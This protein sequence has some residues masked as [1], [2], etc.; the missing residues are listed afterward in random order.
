MNI[1]LR[2][3]QLEAVSMLEEEVRLAADDAARRP[4]AIA[5]SAVT[6]AG[7]T[8]MVAALIERLLLGF[9]DRP[10]MEDVTM[11]WLSHQPHI[12]EQSRRRILG[13]STALG[14]DNAIV[15]ES[16][17]DRET[18][19]PGVLYFLNTQKLAVDR[20][21]TRRSDGRKYTI[22]ETIANTVEQ[23]SGNFVL[24]VDEAHYGTANGRGRKNGGQT[25][26]EHFLF[27]HPEH[28]LTQVK[29]VVGI[30]ATPQRFS[31][32]LQKR[33]DHATRPV[34]VTPQSVRESGLIKE[35]VEIVYS[36]DKSR[37]ADF[38]LLEEAARAW[39]RYTRAWEDYC[40]D[41]G[42][43]TRVLPRLVV[44]VEDARA[45]SGDTRTDL[46]LCVERIK[47]AVKG[48][49]VLD[50]TAFVHTFDREG[51][52]A[53]GDS[54]DIR[55]V[56]PEAIT[57]DEDAK[58]IFF[59]QALSTGWDCPSAEVMM[60]FRSAV[61]H[62]HI[63]QLIGRFIRAP[64]ARRIDSD[65]SLNSAHLFLPRYNRDATDTIIK[66]LTDD[67]RDDPLPTEFTTGSQTLARRDDTNSM[68]KELARLPSWRRA[69]RR[70]AKHT[71]RLSKLLTSLGRDKIGK[72]ARKDAQAEIIALLVPLLAAD[73][74]TGAG[75]DKAAVE[76]RTVDLRAAE[77]NGYEKEFVTA[78]PPDVR[79]RYETI[80]K[81][82][83]GK[84]HDTLWRH[85][86]VDDPAAALHLRSVVSDL[87]SRDQVREQVEQ[88][89]RKIVE[90]LL[91]TH[92]KEIEALAD[93]AK[94]AYTQIMGSDTA[95]MRE[96]TRKY[97]DRI[98]HRP[99]DT[100][101][102]RDKHLYVV[103]SSG[104]FT[105]TLNGS[106]RHVIDAEIASE[107]V[108]GWL[109]NVDR[110]KWAVA[111]PRS[112]GHVMYPDFL[113]VRREGEE[114]VVDL[115][116]P[117]RYGLPDSVDKAKALATYA[118]NHG[119]LFGRVQLIDDIDGTLRRLDLLDQSVRE[120]VRDAVNSDQLRKVY[121]MHG[122]PD[123]FPA[124][125]A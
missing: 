26:V 51:S 120:A 119:A 27:G 97:P 80:G 84:V 102:T 111:I 43:A 108:V 70:P 122:F 93:E 64:L 91:S 55:R 40:S 13:V 123:R 22:W 88:A 48:E 121:E 74:P 39:A 92:K 115:L 3:F 12:N 69:P 17:F 44:Q 4:Q 65:E 109:R 118:E 66:Y 100:P 49:Q 23:R 50:T 33:G 98:V 10:P 106:E 57:D 54:L 94:L 72:D 73:P 21:L 71:Q 77:A 83:G 68:F 15:I 75:S 31:E 7:K 20:T 6:G 79:K 107:S 18:L 45:G 96:P 78:S 58:V 104:E 32:L 113:V 116:D 105:A 52:V 82:V 103:A 38:S 86:T 61:D 117:H 112:G 35:R 2:D 30:S 1:E 9:D 85:L 34:A 14:S 114:L 16:E 60:S 76:R 28:P 19:D 47:D 5:F 89:C 63:A 37:A 29:L 59:K 36:E 42:T 46:A 67:K 24:F 41:H 101:V 87:L 56:D 8:V 110:E 62:T 25:I 53:A 125:P 124:T 11:L 90:R 95:P 99:G 81:D